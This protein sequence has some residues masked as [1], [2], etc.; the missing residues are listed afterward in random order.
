MSSVLTAV[1]K[2]ENYA[3]FLHLI[4][5]VVC[6]YCSPV[7]LFICSF[8][9]S[10]C[11]SIKRINTSCIFWMAGRSHNLLNQLDV[12]DPWNFVFQNSAWSMK[13]GQFNFDSV[14]ASSCP[15]TELNP[16]THR[17]QDRVCICNFFH[18]ETGNTCLTSGYRARYKWCEHLYQVWCDSTCLLTDVVGLIWRAGFIS[19]SGS[20]PTG[21]GKKWVNGK[22]ASDQDS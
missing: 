16:Q 2:F 17:L 9:D 5:A 20:W 4:V 10:T 13:R 18:K 1:H 7:P 19:S 6:S 8:H 11:C 22:S 12:R 3:V 21:I 14:C 15:R